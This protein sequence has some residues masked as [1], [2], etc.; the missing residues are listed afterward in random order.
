MRQPA[1]ILTLLTIFAV[2]SIIPPANSV[3]YGYVLGAERKVVISKYGLAT[4]TDVL[5]IFNNGTSPM[6]TLEF[7]YPKGYSSML[8]SVDARDA[9]GK[10]L[11][12]ERVIDQ[13]SMILRINLETPIQHGSTFK[14]YMKMVFSGL[15]T[16]DGID[17]KLSLQPYPNIPL[18]MASCN[19][20]VI[21]PKDTTLKSWPNQTFTRRTVDEKPAL[22]GR[23]KSMQ[24]L[25]SG[26]V[27]IKFG[28]EGYEL[29]SFESIRREVVMDLLG[30]L[31]SKDT[32]KILNLG[33]E[34][35]YV[36]MPSLEGVRE[37]KAYDATG[38]ISDRVKFKDDSIQVTPRFGKLKTNSSFSFTLEY[39][40]PINGSIRRTSW[41][42][43]YRLTLMLASP[44]D[45][46]AKNY[47]IQVDLPKGVVVNRISVEANSTSVLPDGSYVLTYEY[48]KVVPDRE[49]S[50]TVDYKYKPFMYAIYPVEWI[51]ALEVI[52]GA[53]ASAII[54][55]KPPRIISP[56]SVGKIRRYIEL[57]D[58]KRALRL[59]LER[60]SEEL[61]RGAITKHDYRRVRKSLDSRLS[62]INRSLAT[63]KNE[64]KSID[65]R[66]WEMANRLERAES[67]VEALKA[68]ENQLTSRYRSGQLSREV[69]ESMLSDLRKRI[70]KAEEIIESIIV[71]LREEAR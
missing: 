35:S 4:F 43:D 57:Q 18:S 69:Y 65:S 6:N 40:L 71:M 9:D 64:L 20:T 70:G 59:E 55:R 5:S 23:T 17:Y 38:P 26:E 47:R 67:E 52:I 7:I 60:R 56:T 11:K 28:S 27:Y 37:V 66:Y 14:V 49:Y 31:T 61:S 2:S 24:P 63:L 68:S 3:T 15:V 30:R 25:S 48:S 41:D 54:L 16:F 8:D 19:I 39:D 53:L 62:E 34:L 51:L 33:K 32:Y 42:G 46:V 29:L 10:T 1:I 44:S 12:V 36:T 58:D 45:Y 22:I 13:S 21:F 50:L